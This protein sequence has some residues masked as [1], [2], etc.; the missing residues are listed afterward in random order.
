MAYQ[1]KACYSVYYARYSLKNQEEI[2][3]YNREYRRKNRKAL[4][5]YDRKRNREKLRKAYAKNPM[6]MRARI[7]VHL[8]LSD[9]RLKRG[10]CA[11]GETRVQA[12]HHD[13]SKPLEVVWLCSV[14]HGKEHRRHCG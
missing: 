9:G 7:A 11:C 3:S 6:K 2:A 4:N 8:A 10:V 13:Y 12:H 5:E 1:C 14:C